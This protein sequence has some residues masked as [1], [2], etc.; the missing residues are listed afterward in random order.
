MSELGTGLRRDVK[1][2][3]RAFAALAEDPATSERDYER[4]IDELRTESET[5]IEIAHD[6]EGEHIQHVIQIFFKHFKGKPKLKDGV[7]T[8]HRY[9]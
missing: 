9:L 5:L 6:D 4:K 2:T 8:I 7:R 3:F 1:D